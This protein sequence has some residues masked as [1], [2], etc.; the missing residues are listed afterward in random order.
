[1][2]L[3][4][5]LAPRPIFCGPDAIGLSV[6][7]YSASYPCVL[8]Y[9]RSFSPSIGVENDVL[10]GRQF[11]SHHTR[12]SGTYNSYR[13]I[14]ERL[15][16]WSWIFEGKSVLT[17]NRSD[18]G[19]FCSFC[20]QPPESWIGAGR[21]IRFLNTDSGRVQNDSWRPF[22]ASGQSGSDNYKPFT[23][24]LR[25]VQSI[26]SS[27]FNFLHANDAAAVNPVVMS[28]SKNGRADKR[29]QPSRQLLTSEQISKVIDVLER[30]AVVD[31]ALERPL[32]IVA[33]TVYM[34]LHG[35]DL[36]STD[37]YCPTM[38]C[39]VMEEDNWWFII[40][41]PGSS[42]HKLSVPSHFLPYLKRYRIS[43]GLLPLPG[44]NE[45]EPLLH[46]NRGRLGLC[47][48]HIREVVNDAL[49]QVH[50]D[51]NEREGSC[52]DWN[53]LLSSNMRFLKDSGAKIAALTQSPSEL[54]HNLRSGSLT[55]TYGR[56][57][58]DP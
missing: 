7:Q 17:L 35:T 33:A 14:V 27:F 49:K 36:A 4:T 28:R 41:R 1:M 29:H 2:S 34:C 25:Q 52:A 8:A 46:S 22:D 31:P 6:E 30:L 19:R 47:E 44:R 10:W 42:P 48:R 54:Q 24:A 9:L 11:L 20:E 45:D 21:L 18:F 37:G 43:R 53:I 16:L 40:D 3:T 23:G 13:A 12:V 26:S 58:V 38:N 5:D 32:F 39:F 51:I 15:L 57:Y 55:Y 56:Y 50:A